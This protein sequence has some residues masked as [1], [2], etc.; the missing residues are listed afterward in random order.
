M[1]IHIGARHSAQQWALAATR[2]TQGRIQASYSSTR[3]AEI[4]GL[5]QVQDQPEPHSRSPS[6]ITKSKTQRRAQAAIQTAPKLAARDGRE[7][8]PGGP[9]LTLR[10]GFIQHMPL[11]TQKVKRCCCQPW[12]LGACILP[13]QNRREIPGCSRPPQP[14]LSWTHISLIQ[15]LTCFYLKHVFTFQSPKKNPM[16]TRQPSPRPISVPSPRHSAP[17]ARGTFLTLSRQCRGDSH[18]LLTSSPGLHLTGWEDRTRGTQ[19]PRAAGPSKGTG[20]ARRDQ[21][22]WCSGHVLGQGQHMV[23]DGRRELTQPLF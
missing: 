19:K 6:Q 7:G 10:A 11:A 18:L 1:S 23:H 9:A 8:L 17:Q 12:T 16:D 4:R 21:L 3:E 5:P 2:T 20:P 13:G 15:R 14:R 22:G